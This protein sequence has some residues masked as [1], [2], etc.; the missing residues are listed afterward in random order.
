MEADATD[1]LNWPAPRSGTAAAAHFWLDQLYPA[2]SHLPGPS[3]A[4]LLG[5]MAHAPPIGRNNAQQDGCA[6]ATRLWNG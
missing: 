2:A 6:P 4:R 5:L 3:V 1:A